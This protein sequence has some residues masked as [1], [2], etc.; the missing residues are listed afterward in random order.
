MPAL[1][2]LLALTS[3][4][5]EQAARKHFEHAE[6]LYALGKFQDALVEYEAAYEAKP[7]PGFLFNIGQCY[8]N[9]GNYKQAVFSFK[10][11]LDEKPDAKNRDAVEGLIADLEKKGAEQEKRNKPDLTPHSDPSPPPREVVVARPPEEPEPERPLYA[12]WWFWT[13]IGAAAV[14]AGVAIYAATSS[15]GDS[16]IP[17]TTFHNIDFPR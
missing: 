14:G 11:Y 10:K 2:L 17:D 9:L 5:P 4:T 1:L 13:I 3:A 16:G 12:K 8:R 15:G 6:K 7:L